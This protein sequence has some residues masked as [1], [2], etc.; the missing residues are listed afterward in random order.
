MQFSSE[1]ILDREHFSECYDQSAIINPPKK[2]RY[3]F[4]GALL[5][6]GFIIMM[7]T[8]QSVA[9]GLFFIALAFVEYFSW[10]YAKA[11]WLSRQMWSKNS[12]NRITLT[13]DDEAIKIVSLYQNQ[14][15]LWR[16]I[17]AIHETPLGIILKL[18]NNGQSYLSKS[19]LDNEVIEF[20]KAKTVKKAVSH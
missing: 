17:K 11:W 16:E 14:T 10:K 2:I 7:F 9:V 1:F 18:E 8:D 5:A 13:I 3:N 4:I 6:F 19:S 20:I 12:G 15:F